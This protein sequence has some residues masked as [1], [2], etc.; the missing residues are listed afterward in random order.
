MSDTPRTD[1]ELEKWDESPELKVMI[2]FSRQLERELV[3]AKERVRR[4][5]RSLDL[6]DPRFSRF[7]RTVSQA[8]SAPEGGGQSM[9]D[10][11]RTNLNHLT[12]E[13][14][15]TLKG[16]GTKIVL[17]SVSSRL[18]RELA[19]ANERCKRFEEHAHRLEVFGD[20]LYDLID[21]PSPNCSCHI[22]PPCNDCVEN[23]GFRLA[24]LEWQ[25]AKEA[26]P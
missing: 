24:K 14:L 6:C 4:L 10:T 16:T 8:E 12:V 22:S 23:G 20:V 7:C 3:A 9:S 11:P 5:E 2:R 25:Q 26:K 1:A 15:R 17:A 19:A 18:E 13:T 21:V